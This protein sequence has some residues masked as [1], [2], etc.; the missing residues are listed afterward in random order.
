MAKRTQEKSREGRKNSTTKIL[1][2]REAGI[3]E[4]GIRRRR[5]SG[6]A[7]FRWWRA[8]RA[9]GGPMSLGYAKWPEGPLARTFTEAGCFALSLQLKPR[10]Q[11]ACNSWLLAGY[12]N[13]EIYQSQPAYP[14]DSLPLSLSL[15]SIDL[16]NPSTRTISIDGNVGR[17]GTSSWI[18]VVDARNR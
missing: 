1:E 17:R 11:K 18:C 15:F 16:T 5:R 3:E 9:V 6:K 4:G 14:V 2:K 12:V 13:V 7:D 8:G 10:Y